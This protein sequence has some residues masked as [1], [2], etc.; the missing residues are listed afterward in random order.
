MEEKKH[1]PFPLL[2]KTD[3][4]GRTIYVDWNT[5]ERTIYIYYGATTK[6]KL[7]YKLFHSETS[8]YA[9]DISGNNILSYETGRLEL[10]LPNVWINK[11]GTIDFR[12]DRKKLLEWRKI[13]KSKNK[14]PLDCDTFYY[15][16]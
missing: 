3:N 12:V 4:L 14:K 2:K 16:V 5:V 13:S 7:K 1:P 10:T 6:I 11:E 15:D 8:L 9:Y